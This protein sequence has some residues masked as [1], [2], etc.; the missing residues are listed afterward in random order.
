MAL[1][2]VYIYMYDRT[3]RSV[4]SERNATQM[5]VNSTL[6]SSN[7]TYDSSRCTCICADCKCILVC[8]WNIIIIALKIATLN[9]SC[10]YICSYMIVHVRSY[11]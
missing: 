11:M 7:A 4:N 10:C 5:Y 9:E 8:N 2:L 3:V 1:E 6:A